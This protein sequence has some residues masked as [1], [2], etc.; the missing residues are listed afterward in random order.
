MKLRISTK[1]FIESQWPETSRCSNI[2]TGKTRDLQRTSVCHDVISI[3]V[4]LLI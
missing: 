2:E 3:Q 4:Q 1:A